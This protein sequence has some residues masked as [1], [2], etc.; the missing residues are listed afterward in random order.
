MLD[1]AIT[2]HDLLLH[3][4]TCAAE[5]SAVEMKDAE[6]LLKV[7]SL[8]VSHRHPS[9]NWPCLCLRI[10]AWRT[11]DPQRMVKAGLLHVEAAHSLQPHRSGK[12]KGKGKGKGGGKAAKGEKDLQQD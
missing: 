7:G 2:L 12:G 8:H 9:K 10:S 6:A 1:E 11:R 3:C 5:A 4:S